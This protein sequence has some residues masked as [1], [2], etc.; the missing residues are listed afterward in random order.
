M[1]GCI[2]SEGLHKNHN[3]RSAIWVCVCELCLEETI[4]CHVRVRERVSGLHTAV[5]PQVKKESHFLSAKR[6][7]VN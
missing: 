6:L 2:S 1:K 4:S 3:T 5:D 7:G